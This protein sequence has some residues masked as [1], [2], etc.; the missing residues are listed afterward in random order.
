[1]SMWDDFD[2]N[3]MTDE[4]INDLSSDI[5]GGYKQKQGNEIWVEKGAGDGRAKVPTGQYRTSTN[6]DYYKNHPGWSGVADKLDLSSV[7][8]KSDLAQMNAYVLGYNNTDN[9]DSV[10]KDSDDSDDEPI[11]R[12][13]PDVATPENTEGLEKARAFVN[14]YTQDLVSGERVKRLYGNKYDTNS[15]QQPKESEQN[16]QSLLAKYQNAYRNN[17]PSSP[18]D[19]PQPQKPPQAPTSDAPSQFKM[20]QG[21]MGLNTSDKDNEGNL[22][23]TSPD[24]DLAYN[25]F[26]NGVNPFRDLS[27]RT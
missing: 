7:N 12:K 22:N 5:W 3:K 1:M 16:A 21:L 8:S 24:A 27:F 18:V 19:K 13:V 23:S 20:A 25:N 4:Q 11:N 9:D 14:D 15:F 17:V 6:F 2:P 26:L 10:N